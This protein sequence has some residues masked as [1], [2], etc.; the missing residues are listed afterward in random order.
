MYTLEILST[1]FSFQPI[2]K[3]A[4]R[5][6]LPMFILEKKKKKKKACSRVCYYLI[7]IP[8]HT[9]MSCSSSAGWWLAFFLLQHVGLSSPSRLVALRLQSNS[10][11]FPDVEGIKYLSL[12]PLFEEFCWI[13]MAFCPFLCSG[14]VYGHSLRWFTWKMTQHRRLKPPTNAACLY[15]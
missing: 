4:L 9:G 12:L 6:F 11:G 14:E 8:F 1:R 2:W 5:F 10:S 3:F 15:T 13:N 7:H